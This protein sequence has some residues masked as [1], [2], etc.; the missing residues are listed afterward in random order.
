MKKRTLIIAGSATAALVGLAAGAALLGPRILEEEIAERVKSRL[1]ARGVEATW[2]AFEA[3]GGGTFA[4]SDVEVKA[5][6]YGASL[7]SREMEVSVAVGSIWSGDVRLTDVKLNPA[8]VTVDLDRVLESG[9]AEDGE[10]PEEPADDDGGGF[11][12]R[13]LENPPTVELVDAELELLR[14]GKPAVKITAPSI[15][16]DESWGKFS[17]AFDGSVELLN[18]KRTSILRRE[19][20]WH[21]SG[22]VDPSAGSFE[23]QI[24]SPDEADAL[25]RLYVP[26]LLRLEVQTVWGEGTLE[27]RTAQVNLGNLE[28]VVGG[29]EY[30]ALH[31][32]APRAVLSRQ[33]SGRPR[34]EIVDPVV[35][36][37]PSRR[38]RAMEV[39]ELFR[40][41][42][43]EPESGPDD[44]RVGEDDPEPKTQVDEPAKDA[45]TQ[46]GGSAFSRLARLASQT[47]VEL[48]GLSV[49]VHLEKQ[50]GTFNSV[51]LLER[52]DTTIRD[53]LVRAKGTSAGGEFFAEAEVLPGQSWPHYLIARARGVRLEKVP[54]LS[55]ER[56]QLPSRG[57][58][59]TVGG[60][61][62]LDLALTM[63]S[64]GMAGP[65]LQLPGVG[66]FRVRWRDG[67]LDLEGVADVPV[68]G[69]D[70]G[71]DFTF[72]LQ[73][74]IASVEITD[75]VV[76][77]GPVT[78]GVTGSITDFPLDTEFYFDWW[79][80]EVDC[81]T[82]F[83][84]LPDALLG[85][86]KEVEFDGE[87]AP[88]GWLRFPLYRPLGVRASFANY[89]DRC[90]PTALNAAQEAWPD[91]T[92]A[93]RAPTG[94]HEFAAPLPRGRDRA[95]LDDVYWLNRPFIKRVT[96]GVS[97]PEQVEIYVGPGTPQYVPIE[98][99]PSWTGGAAYLSEQI[100][101]YFDGPVSVSLMKKAM[102]LN[103]SKGRF[104][105]GGST[106]T[107]QLVKNLFLTREKTIA[108][109]IQEA[110][111]AWRIDEAIAKDRVLELYLNCIEFGEDVYGIGPAARHYFQKDARYLTPK[112][113]IFLAML[114]PAPWFGER[115]MERGTTPTGEYFT[116]RIA[117]LHDRLVDYH[118]ITDE[119]REAQK[120]YTLEWE[121]GKYKGAQPIMLLP[122]FGEPD[123][124]SPSTP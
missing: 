91:V 84:A 102:R 37:T 21:F 92:F 95:V 68:T 1:E 111:I 78:A 110:L 117:E 6:R 47:D 118:Y 45:A 114:K 48:S 54:G 31:A 122:I 7:S 39:I 121:G 103:L 4:I 87:W 124:A 10:T 97:D 89:E 55:R 96:E 34:V 62:D 25:F 29:E 69:I 119:Q 107:Q 32:K 51:T 13:L 106:V 104:V 17:V 65:L 63:P 40:P 75:G 101:F 30:A 72:T 76:R 109:K 88:T 60:E 8:R 82:M 59:G 123:R 71:A 11:V 19:I 113:S 41:K 42:K 58:S 93:S 64:R 2:G 9:L 98:K 112:E 79:I 100:D 57:T 94:P 24:R 73:P 66:E 86:Y 43:S 44:V 14:D 35:Y 56:S 83:R 5:P 22:S 15:A 116:K 49:G 20:P 80:E 77:Y 70:T 90:T 67:M 81:Q 33:R 16:V 120:P 23:Y 115:I 108:R 38:G 36:A 85:P 61:V 28:L 18:V 52:L 27:D 46:K 74:E 26:E 99:L 50:D 12:R 53:G 105:Y 3:R